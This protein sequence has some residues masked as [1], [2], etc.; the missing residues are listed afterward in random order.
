MNT[1]IQNIVSLS[2]YL[3]TAIYES[4]YVQN[5]MIFDFYPGIFY[6]K[7]TTLFL[8]NSYFSNKF[9]SS[10]LENTLSVI[11]AD[12]IPK[13]MIITNS[14]FSFISMKQ[15]GGVIKIIYK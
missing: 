5:L 12:S 13:K 2:D 4:C 6:F 9:H 1:V 14:V 7:N 10:L 15:N 11:M 8:S 3:I